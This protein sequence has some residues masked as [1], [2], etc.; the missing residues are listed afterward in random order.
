MIF[1][2]ATSAIDNETEVSI[3]RTFQKLSGTKTTI[4]IAHRLSTVRHAHRIVVL[5]DGAI[6]ESGDHES[7]LELDGR[8]ARMWAIQ[9]GRLE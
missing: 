7:L 4:I 8:Y 3:Q 2:E 9:T 6:K 1:D 5:E